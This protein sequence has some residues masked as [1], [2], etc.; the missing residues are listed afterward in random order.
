MRNLTAAELEAKFPKLRPGNYKHAS[1]ATARYNCVAFAKD[2]VRKWWEAGQHGGRYDWPP[3][4]PDTLEGWVEL[5]TE[6]GYE[7]TINREIEQ[8]FEKI[9]I[10]VDLEDMRPDHVAKSNGRTWKSKLGRIQDIEHSSLELLEGDQHWEYGIVERIL[11]RPIK[12]PT[13]K[14]KSES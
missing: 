6:E 9:A 12:K 7:I 3:H 1:D 8:G 11:R 10:Y 13:A 4:I 5:F 14:S 2:K